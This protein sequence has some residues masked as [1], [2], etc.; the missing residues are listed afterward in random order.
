M[1]RT[2]FSLMCIGIGLLGALSIAGQISPGSRQVRIK[3]IMSDP[4]KY[5]DKVVVVE[6]RVTKYGD[7]AAG[8]AKSYFLKGKW[9]GM[10]KIIANDD[11][12][13]ENVWG[14]VKGI[15]IISDNGE[16]FIT[17]QT[18]IMK[19]PGPEEGKKDNNSGKGAGGNSPG[20]PWNYALI[21]ASIILFIFIVVLSLLLI[22]NQRQTFLPD[23]LPETS[24]KFRLRRKKLPKPAKVIDGKTIVIAEAPAGTLKLLPGR[25][26]VLNGDDTIREIRFYKTR[27]QGE[28]E[29][30]FGREVE[31][32]YSHIQLKPR[33]VSGKH[34]KL[35]WTNGKYSLFNYSDVNPTTVNGEPMAKE[36]SVVLEPGCRIEMGEVAFIYHEK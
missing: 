12:P 8:K 33:T 24:R 30:T 4:Y 9:G 28:T 6:G 5:Q 15:V 35:V 34:A 3:D 23:A 13:E 22:F 21:G 1:R 26:E 20:S 27:H 36:A 19:E 7:E 18:R 25:F 2:I 29:I 17:G 14:T 16:T 11:L 31:P 10:I 32:D